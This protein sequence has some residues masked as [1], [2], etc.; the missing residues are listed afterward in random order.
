MFRRIVNPILVFFRE[1]TLRER[2]ERMLPAAVIGALAGTA[3]VLTLATINVISLPALHLSPDWGSL[4]VHLVEYDLA[5]ALAGAIAGWFTEDPAGAIGGGIV[6]TLLYLIVNWLII[7]LTG[8][9]PA[10]LVQ[11]LITAVPLLIG[12]MLLCAV[13]RFAVGRY[14]R[15]MQ[16]KPGARRSLRLAG[17]LVLVILVGMTPGSFAH[18]DQNSQNVILA[19]DQRLQAVAGEPALEAQFP[20]AQFPALQSHFGQPFVLQPRPSASQGSALDVTIRYA[21]GYAITCLVPT[22]DPYVQYFKQ[23]Y[24]GNNVILP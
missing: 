5:L 3:Y 19:M 2:S 18:F 10:R 11:L 1:E 13:Y 23:C 20:L 14:V 16:T 8:N 17:M 4:L 7:R 22:N 9:S 15:L 24:L 21:D 12:A 6:S